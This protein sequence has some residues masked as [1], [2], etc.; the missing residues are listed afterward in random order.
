MYE[1]IEKPASSNFL[2]LGFAE[3]CPK[4]P[5]IMYYSLYALLKVM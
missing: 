3:S 1:W 4:K 5:H 2:S